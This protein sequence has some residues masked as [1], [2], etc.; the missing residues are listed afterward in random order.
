LFRPLHSEILPLSFSIV[1]ALINSNR[2]DDLMYAFNTH[3]IFVVL[4]LV[5][6]TFQDSNRGN[7]STRPCIHFCIKRLSSF[8][9]SFAGGF[10]CSFSGSFLCFSLKSGLFISLF[11]GKGCSFYF[12]LL[13]LLLPFCYLSLPF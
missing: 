5:F 1:F 9:C 8:Y 3:I 10:C 7:S 6:R 12:I 11:F 13:C 4:F 2:S